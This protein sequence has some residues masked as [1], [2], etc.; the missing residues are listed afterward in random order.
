[1]LQL[2][3]SAGHR[4]SR[5]LVGAGIVRDTRGSQPLHSALLVPQDGSGVDYSTPCWLVLGL[6]EPSGM[7]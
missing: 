5:E 4:A 2:I 7:G 6:S 3:W 1:M